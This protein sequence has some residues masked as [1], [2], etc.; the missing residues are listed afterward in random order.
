MESG[1][2]IIRIIIFT[3]SFGTIVEQLTYFFSNL[4]LCKYEQ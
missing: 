3:I 1:N 4:I 2:V